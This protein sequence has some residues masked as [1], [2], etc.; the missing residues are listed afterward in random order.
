[1]PSPA[2]GGGRHVA[3]REETCL[4]AIS[5]RESMAPRAVGTLNTYYVGTAVNRAIRAATVRERP[6]IRAATVRERMSRTRLVGV[7][8]PH[9]RF[10]CVIPRPDGM[11]GGMAKRSAAM[12]RQPSTCDLQLS[13]FPPAP[14]CRSGRHLTFCSLHVIQRRLQKPF[15]DGSL[16]CAAKPLQ[17]HPTR[18][19]VHRNKE[20]NRFH[21]CRARKV[22]F[23]SRFPAPE[24][25]QKSFDQRRDKVSVP[26]I[27]P[28]NA[29]SR[30]CLW[31]RGRCQ[32]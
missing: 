13:T 22:R 24:G 10:W 7:S 25:R 29:A 18:P 3:A 12:F 5:S 9:R 11:A 30:L 27:P 15:T 2:A 20:A 28:E 16:T 14:R 31:P 8:G 26:R 17:S 6:A 19:D 4:P 32:G 21:P 23:A 1:M